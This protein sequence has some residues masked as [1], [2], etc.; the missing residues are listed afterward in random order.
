MK[1]PAPYRL[2]YAMDQALQKGERMQENDVRGVLEWLHQVMVLNT[3]HQV[4]FLADEVV[5][6]ASALSDAL[7]DPMSEPEETCPGPG[8][9][10]PSEEPSSPEYYC[11]ACHKE[12]A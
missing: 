10:H 5:L 3:D 4:T 7:G 9:L 11:A 2:M 8:N 1:P 6:I 12:D